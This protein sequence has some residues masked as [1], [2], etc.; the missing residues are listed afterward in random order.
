MGSAFGVE[1]G[2]TQGQGVVDS[3]F[4]KTPPVAAQVFP[5]FKFHVESDRPLGSTFGVEGRSTQ[6]QG[7]VDS[8]K[9][10][11]QTYLPQRGRPVSLPSLP[12][13]TNP[14]AHRK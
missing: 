4:L 5:T 8:A 2:S 12:N 13:P 3:E 7:V 9:T 14:G 10:Y 1:R 6:G 11:L